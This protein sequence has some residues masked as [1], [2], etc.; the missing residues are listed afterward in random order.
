MLKKRRKKR[1]D[2][3]T[4]RS[5]DKDTLG[6]LYTGLERNTALKRLASLE[7][8][9][10][11]QLPDITADDSFPIDVTRISGQH[12]RRQLS[13]WTAQFAR[14]NALLGLAK[15]RKSVLERKVDREKK[16]R[17]KIVAPSQKS[18]TYVDAVWGDV[19]TS[20][21]I[22]KLEKLLD[23]AIEIEEA[24][25]ALARDFSKYSDVLQAELMYR[26]SEMKLTGRG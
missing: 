9:F 15:G 20:Q 17:F 25:N 8:P 26:Q 3:L 24:L 7:I 21:N 1:P 5:I 16:I 13:Y 11:S 4:A 12:L 6:K 10:P 18:K 23:M 19:Q 22:A 2:I 14:V